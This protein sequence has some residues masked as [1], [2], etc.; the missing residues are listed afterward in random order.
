MYTTHT[1]ESFRLEGG[2]I[3]S[4]CED[5]IT[6][7]GWVYLNLDEAFITYVGWLLL[8]VFSSPSKDNGNGERRKDLNFEFL[9]SAY[10][11]S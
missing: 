11:V 7:V 9:V 10:C 8:V 1:S 6:W 3:I 5:G 4:C 2:V